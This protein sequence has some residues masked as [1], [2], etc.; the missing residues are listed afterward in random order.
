MSNQRQTN[1]NTPGAP[2]F[3]IPNPP[4]EFGQDGGGFYRA[5]DTL[6]E[7]LDVDMTE[8]L[9]EQL[10][11]MLVF[12]GLFAGVNSAFLAL[13][14]PLL[15][16]DPSD[17]TN[18]L[19]S[20]ILMQLATGMNDTASGSSALPSTTFSPSS[21][22]FTI[23]SLFGLS[24]AL[25][26]IASFLAV[27]GRQWL[28]YY[29]KRSGSGPDRQ[30]WEQL[31]RF[32]GAK[33]WR[34]ELIL[35]DMLPFILQIA[36]II[37]CVSLI[38]YLHHLNPA[39]SIVVGMPM[40]LG[41]L[42]FIGSAMCTLWDRFCPF[43]SPLSHLLCWGV[44][45]APYALRGG[46]GAVVSG[47]KSLATQISEKT[48]RWIQ[49]PSTSNSVHTD[50][51]SQAVDQATQNTRRLR[52]GRFAHGITTNRWFRTLTKGRTEES[53]ESLQVIALQRAIC[54]SDD[55][56]TLLYASSNILGI[57]TADQMEQLWSDGIFLERFFN[58]FLNLYNQALL[59]GGS[60]QPTIAASAL[61][62][63]CAAAAHSVLVL[64]VGWE[65]LTDFVNAI[66][67]VQEIPIWIPDKELPGA[68]ICLIRTTLAFTIFQ[69]YTDNPSF[70]TVKKF[71]AHLDIYSNCLERG[72]WR[73]LCVISWVVTNL[74][75]TEKAVS[76]S[77]NSLRGAYRGDF[78]EAVRTLPEAFGVL[79]G[80]EFR[81]LLDND[82]ILRNML[83]FLGQVIVDKTQST[84]S[85]K[86]K[87]NLSACWE[88]IMPNTVL[89][90]ATRQIVRK[91]RM[92]LAQ[93]WQRECRKENVPDDFVDMIEDYLTIIRTNYKVN[94][95]YHEYIEVLQLFGPAIRELLSHKP[96]ALGDMR[97][98]RRKRNSLRNTFNEMVLDAADI[99]LKIRKNTRRV[100]DPEGRWCH[101]QEDRLLATYKDKPFVAKKYYRLDT[102]VRTRQVI[103]IRANH[104]AIRDEI[105]RYGKATLWL[106]AFRDSARDARID[107][108]TRIEITDAFIAEEED[109][110][111][112][113]FEPRRT[114]AD[115]IKFSET[116]RH[117]MQAHR[118]TDKTVQ[119]FVHFAFAQC[120]GNL[121]FA[122]AKEAL[123][124][125]LLDMTVLFDL[126]THTTEE[127][128]GPG[129]HGTF[130]IQAW[131]EQ[132]SCNEICRAFEAAGLFE[133]QETSDDDGGPPHRRPRLETFTSSEDDEIVLLESPQRRRKPRDNPAMRQPTP[134]NSDDEKDLPELSKPARMPAVES[135]TQRLSDNDGV[136]LSTA[137]SEAD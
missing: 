1:A 58:Q 125:F 24:L 137:G 16:G 22:I 114:I 78:D 40:Y 113:L 128:S 56:G 14:L 82:S 129:D 10:E 27:L 93:V 104:E 41:L 64:N 110:T 126:M 116:M 12:A 7:E 131:E 101:A 67:M 19:L 65:G 57:G 45:G 77:M 8:S 127:D 108:D 123:A 11:G 107:I 4:N 50:Y 42:I 115:P 59:I 91:L 48:T 49:Q 86:Q 34:L 105:V 95:V 96:E 2:P 99:S 30:R 80:R 132:H 100:R 89:P 111:A 106:N 31:E 121:V 13:T 119:A 28:V 97:L 102:T 39:L 36:L 109:G 134:P 136:P 63:Y 38:M 3:E 33:R 54:T 46:N 5:Y 120:S 55:P 94:P 44:K 118:Q 29:R 53:Q 68:S 61:R 52:L 43:H 17:D 32:L 66:H 37:F 83:L 74:T 47:F 85:M 84:V 103:S 60:D 135:S 87:F 76:P 62:L 92:N 51:E 133:I 25:A 9:K 124:S 88:R 23:N 75:S 70:E 122:D 69:F 35:D 6:A 72:D 117:D 81:E 71:Y 79:A 26:I 18:A 15:S 90:E 130:G 21:N 73:L 112:W 98:A 20:Q